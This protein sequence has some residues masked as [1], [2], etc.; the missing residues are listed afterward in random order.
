MIL[1]EATSALDS[2]SE[3][4]INDAISKISKTKTI[5]VIAHRLS[6]IKNADRILFFKNGEIIESGN[7]ND[8]YNLKGEYYNLYNVQF[9][10]N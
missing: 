4:K 5:I 10:K 8:L 9:N 3:V 6:T 1:D 7:H 2:K